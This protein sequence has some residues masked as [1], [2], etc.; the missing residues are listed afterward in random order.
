MSI[1]RTLTDVS[2]ENWAGVPGCRP[3]EHTVQIGTG[4]DQWWLATDA[5]MRWGTKTRSGFT[6][7]PVS[8]T[9]VRVIDGADYILIASVGPLRIREP[10]RVV[11]VVDLP[12]QSG[13]AYGTRPGHPVTGEEAFIVHR[14]ADGR[15]WFTLRSLTRPGFGRWRPAFPIILVANACTA[16]AMCEP[17][18]A[19]SA[20]LTSTSCRLPTARMRKPPIHTRIGGFAVRVRG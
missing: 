6:V 9:Q 7:Q 17:C 5:V 20:R 4:G 3:Y 13:F 18:A 16:A 15:V 10:V 19:S 14:T 8:G 11:S 12:D 1:E 2:D